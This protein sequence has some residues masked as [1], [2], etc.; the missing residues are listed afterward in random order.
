MK[1]AAPRI[2][3]DPATGFADAEA[4]L[5]AFW[6]GIRP[7]PVQ[8]VAEWSEANR[9][10]SGEAASEPGPW[11]NAR[12]PYLVEIM[13]ALSP[14]SRVEEVVFQKSAQ[15]GGTECGNNWLAYIIARGLGPTLAVSK[16]VGL[17]ERYS[18]QRIDPM[19]RDTPALRGKIADRRLRDSGNTILQKAFPGGALL[20]AGAE[21][22][23]GLR[24]MPIRNLFLD[25]IDAYPD[26]VEGEGDP[27]K[28]AERRTMTFARRKVFKVST[29]TREASSKIAAA[30]RETDQRVYLVPCPHCG[31][32]QRLVWAGLRFDKDDDGRVI[33]ESVRYECE[34]CGEA[35]R[36]HHKRAMLE[37]GRWT[38]TA[39]EPTGLRRGY[40]ISALYSP[41]FP[42]WKVAHEFVQAQDSAERLISFVNTILGET[43]KEVA[44]TPEWRHLYARRESWRQG[45]VP[46]GGH[47][48]TAG[49]DVQRDR[50]ELEVVA[51]GPRMESWS[52]EFVVLEGDPAAPAVWDKLEGYLSRTWPH[53]SG[54]ELRIA[55]LAID[56]GDQTQIV[57]SWARRFPEQVLPVKGGPDSMSEI[58]GRA[59]MQDI[60][61]DGK[62]V[63]RGVKVW[64][65]G[66]GT[67]KHEIYAY[68]RLPPPT[69]EED[70]PRGFVHFPADRDA[71]WFEQLCGEAWVRE[72][73]RRTKRYRWR[74]VKT[75]ERNE[76]LDCRVYA[77][78]ALSSLGAD[79]WEPEAWAACLSTWG[80]DS[81]PVGH[82]GPADEGGSTDRPAG[83]LAR[84]QG[85]RYRIR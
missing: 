5:E 12:T 35:F 32:A 69:D 67:I 66:S 23:A 42:W 17:A 70:A 47:V 81:G 40:H 46:M 6:R 75:R 73:D 58:L 84:H 1:V 63:R 71:E 60:R 19:V 27:V 34:A 55:R 38:P 77:R 4:L 33:P 85:G 36:E 64:P 8:D 14:Q 57:Y 11:R 39:D 59:K 48:L 53:E 50:L 37:G 3:V 74:W 9:V 16:S 56:S 44:E 26:D 43:W 78:A 45:T 28:L 65:V 25:E 51:W 22:A 54:T 83:Y 72:R 24:S 13:E 61:A 10:L 21:S 7:D 49:V 80:L 29:P 79:R 31:H 20:L 18:K 41:W 82:S 2:P 30:Y 15:V 76:A 62:R 68:L 52:V